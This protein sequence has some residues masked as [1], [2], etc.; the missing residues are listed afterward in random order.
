MSEM[1]WL[2]V[3]IPVFQAEGSISRTI[4]SITDQGAE[5]VEIVCVDDCSPD[6]SVEV[7]EALQ[8][9]HPTLRL[10]RQ[11]RNLG[12]GPT[13]NTGIESATGD[14]VLFLDSDDTLITGGL[15]AL[16]HTVTATLAYVVFVGCEEVR[17]GTAR[18][19]T[20][21][22]LAD[23]L[24]NTPT[25]SVEEHPR[26]LFWPPSPW[27][28]VYRRQF[29]NDRAIR[30]GEG[31]AEDIPWSAKVTLDAQT[32]A[33]CDAPVYRYVTADKDTSVTTTSSEK[34]MA[35]VGQVTTMRHQAELPSLG[36][37]IASHLATLAAIHLIW[38]NR[39]AYR[40]L[41]GHLRE[42]FFHRS[43]TEIAAWLKAADIPPSLD[44]RPLM[45]AADR[46]IYLDAL[47]SGNYKRWG[48]TLEGQEQRKK[49]RRFFRAGK[50]FGKK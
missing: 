42:E 29:L 47:A 12:P 9:D 31:V 24:R 39:A 44:S 32:I 1:P 5:G 28:K 41:P 21:G 20:G 35:I 33:L 13:R 43:S 45:S 36:S 14:Y 23:L 15:T 17:R 10:I 6:S 2:S 7:I 46:T 40:L 3:V 27:S 37:D 34:N 11:D 30:F 4:S 48:K 26:V 50:A 19:L 16:H 25:T 49:F 22:P 38:P 8:R 18:S